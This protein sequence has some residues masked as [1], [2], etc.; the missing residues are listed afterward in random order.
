MEGELGPIA[1]QMFAAGLVLIF[2]GA[3]TAAFARQT[4]PTRHEPASVTL[5]RFAGGLVV[6]IGGGI[7][8]YA[9]NFSG[10]LGR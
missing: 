10:N 2:L 7:A 5:M 9:L 4:R 6:L 1:W 8:M 3:G